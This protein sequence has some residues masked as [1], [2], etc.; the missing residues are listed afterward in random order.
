PSRASGSSPVSE[1]C[2]YCGHA[3]RRR[4]SVPSFGRR[5]KSWTASVPADAEEDGAAI[6]DAFVDDIALLMGAHDWSE[7]HRRY[8]ALVHAL[9]WVM[10]NRHEFEKAAR[11]AATA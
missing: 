1:S 9:D 11:T 3:T 4:P 10:H 2:P 8:W 7:R 5:R 6:L